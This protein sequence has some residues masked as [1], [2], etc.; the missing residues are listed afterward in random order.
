MPDTRYIAVN[1]IRMA[2][3]E[4]GVGPGVVLAHGFPELAYSWR[5]QIDA[6]A[7]AGFRVIVPDLR[8]YGETEQPAD[9][10]SYDIQHLTGG[11]YRFA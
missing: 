1:G 3:H 7:R 8:G 5:Y 2:F 10:K 4:S 6:I 11:L 9:V